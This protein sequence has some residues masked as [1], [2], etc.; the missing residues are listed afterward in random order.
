MTVIVAKDYDNWINSANSTNLMFAWYV[1]LSS[2]HSFSFFF[3]LYP[4]LFHSAF[5][6]LCT[7]LVSCYC[8]HMSTISKS[9]YVTTNIGFLKNTASGK[10]KPFSSPYGYTMSISELS[11]LECLNFESQRPLIIRFRRIFFQI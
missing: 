1:I 9:I 2:S 10:C 8:T 4:Q 6:F 7:I 3:I 5:I 11:T